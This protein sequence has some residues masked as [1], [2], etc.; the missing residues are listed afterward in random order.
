MVAMT[1]FGYSANG[2]F[3]SQMSHPAQ[4]TALVT[5]PW[6]ERYATMQDSH[7]LRGV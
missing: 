4:I 2:N 6:N 3:L 1:I 5:M 7:F